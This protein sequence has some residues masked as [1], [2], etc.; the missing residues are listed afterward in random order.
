MSKENIVR[1]KEKFKEIMKSLDGSI[2][3]VFIRVSTR[4]KAGMLDADLINMNISDAPIS[5]AVRDD[6]NINIFDSGESN[7]VIEMNDFD[8]ADIQDME[9]EST[10]GFLRTPCKAISIWLKNTK[11]IVIYYWTEEKENK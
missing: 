5:V 7:F 6:G 4:E 9:K 2:K 1:D 8:Y 11:F 10:F 3:S